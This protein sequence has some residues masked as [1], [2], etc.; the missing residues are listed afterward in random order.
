LL[1]EILGVLRELS[2]LHVPV[3]TR[4]VKWPRSNVPA[5]PPSSLPVFC[6]DASVSNYADPGDVFGIDFIHEVPPLQP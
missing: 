3:P 6:T 4:F 1:R 5:D 2:F